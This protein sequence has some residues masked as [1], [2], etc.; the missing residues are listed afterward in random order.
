MFVVKGHT[1]ALSTI[2][3]LIAFHVCCFLF[4]NTSKYVVIVCS[5]GQLKLVDRMARMGLAKSTVRP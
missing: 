1:S 5:C 2:I 4:C 3:A